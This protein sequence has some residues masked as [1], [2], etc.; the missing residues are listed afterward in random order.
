MAEHEDTM[1]LDE[2]FAGPSGDQNLQEPVPKASTDPAS[3]SFKQTEFCL[4]GTI[5]ATTGLR[6]F[7]TKVYFGLLLAIGSHFLKVNFW[8]NLA[9]VWAKKAIVGSTFKISNGFVNTANEAFRVSPLTVEVLANTLSKIE[10]HPNAAKPPLPLTSFEKLIKKPDLMG[11][12]VHVEGKVVNVKHTE[13]YVLVKLVGGE[14]ELEILLIFNNV[15]FDQT[16]EENCVLNVF[17]GKVSR[18]GTDLAIKII[19][20]S[21]FTCIHPETESSE[22][23]LKKT[24]N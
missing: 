12:L 3:L 2:L 8:N 18:F 6:T 1:H 19:D 14:D 24:K 13:R 21:R 22:S 5:V 7:N 16:I 9:K 4:E 17:Y 11:T 20:L 15:G 23:T 10:I